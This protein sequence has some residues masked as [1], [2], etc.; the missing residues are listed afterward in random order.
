[1]VDFRLLGPLEVSVDGDTVPL[2]GIKQRAVLGY[3][4]LQANRVVAVS[5]LLEALW[6]GGTEPRTARRILQN[7]VW[8]LR[9]VLPGGEYSHGERTDSRSA[10]SSSWPK[11]LTREPGYI[12]EVDLSRVDLYRFRDD[13]ATGREH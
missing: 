9:G 11:L 1:V 12:L 5:E 10:E 3:L 8:R 6:S 4:L 2:G 7:A 13:V